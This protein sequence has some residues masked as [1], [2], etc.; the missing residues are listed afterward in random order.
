MLYK[1]VYIAVLFLTKV[2]QW[3]RLA[4]SKGPNWPEDGKR[5]SFRNVVFFNFL[6]YWTMGKVQKRSNS[7]SQQI[8]FDF[9]LENIMVSFLCIG[10]I[11]ITYRIRHQENFVHT[12]K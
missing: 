4:L 10:D 9:P 11:R 7:E 2:V 12:R 6:E 1:G 5:S 3:L 8:C